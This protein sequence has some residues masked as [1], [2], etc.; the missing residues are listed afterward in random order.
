MAPE[1]S[2][3][4]RREVSTTEDVLMAAR[5]K[6]NTHDIVITPCLS[7]YFEKKLLKVRLGTI[8]IK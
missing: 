5:I 6:K 1:S 3:S 4:L 7:F 2:A 8:E